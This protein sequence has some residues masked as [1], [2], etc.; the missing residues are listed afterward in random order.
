VD[1]V[2]TQYLNYKCKLVC[3]IHNVLWNHNYSE[4]LPCPGLDAS[5]PNMVCAAGECVTTAKLGW[6]DIEMA[7]AELSTKA[8]AYADV[9]IQNAT[10][11]VT[12][13]IKNRTTCVSC[14]TKAINGT[15]HPVWT[16]VCTGSHTYKWIDGARVT[17][18][19]WDQI[20]TTNNNFIGGA[21]LTIQ[22]L[23]TNGDSHKEIA[24]PLAGG[25][26]SG[27]IYVRVTWTAA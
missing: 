10:T 1:A 19:V 11:A 3:S 25:P 5:T 27:K 7:S 12:L 16:A 18:E 2:G 4:G 17:F 8:N 6:I 22:Q 20:S 13:P 24:L 23:L 15:L 21:S 26:G 14:A 9:C